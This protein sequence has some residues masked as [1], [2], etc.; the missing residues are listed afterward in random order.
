[1]EALDLIQHTHTQRDAPSSLSFS[2]CL[3]V[4]SQALSGAYT[5]ALASSSRWIS[6]GRVVML[7]RARER[8]LSGSRHTARGTVSYKHGHTE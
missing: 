5:R 3:S 4:S 8:I 2:L 1:M 7:L 6:T